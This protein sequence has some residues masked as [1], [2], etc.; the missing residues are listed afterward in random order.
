MARIVA[1]CR[2]DKK[3]IS[4]T[5]IDEG[6]FQADYGLANDARRRDICQSNQRR[7]TQDWR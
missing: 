6:F 7:G 1:V 5:P 2:S 3:G 4:K